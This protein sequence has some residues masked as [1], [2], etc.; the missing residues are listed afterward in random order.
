M[1][2]TP[3]GISR[4]TS[5]I[6]Y[7]L[8]RS[9]GPTIQKTGS[10]RDT[11]Q[12]GHHTRPDGPNSGGAGMAAKFELSKDKAGKFRFHLKSANGEIIAASQ[13][14]MIRQRFNPPGAAGMVGWC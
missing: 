9:P 8:S 4:S 14:L 12:S 6:E 7:S 1:P 2:V 10:R 13:A 11:S 5:I 3:S